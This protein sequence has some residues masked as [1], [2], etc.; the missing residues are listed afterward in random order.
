MTSVD[1]VRWLNSYEGH[2]VFKLPLY[3]TE[4]TI[5]GAGPD[6]ESLQAEVLRDYY[7]L[8]F[9]VPMMAGITYWNFADGTAVEGENEAK[10]GL[11]DEAMQPKPAYR[12]LER[13]IHEEWS[14]RVQARTDDRGVA[15][16]RGFYGR[17]EAVVSH[18]GVTRKFEV[19]HARAG[20]KRHRLTF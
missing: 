9:S 1:P 8:W 20:E 12:A 2:G 7:R 3:I 11:V 14:T 6:G 5:P 15:G 19:N 4:I 17:Y 18:G 13:L 16:F 10:G